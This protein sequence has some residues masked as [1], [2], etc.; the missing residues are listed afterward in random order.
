MQIRKVR[1]GSAS[2]DFGLVFIFHSTLASLGDG[3]DGQLIWTRR[4]RRQLTHGLI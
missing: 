4:L 2:T 3:H 1:I